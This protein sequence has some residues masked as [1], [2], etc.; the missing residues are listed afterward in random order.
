MPPCAAMFNLGPCV[1]WSH[2]QQS[3]VQQAPCLPATQ[4]ITFGL[5]APYLQQRRQRPAQAAAS[6][7]IAAL[8]EAVDSEGAAADASAQAVA[9]ADAVAA[10]F[11]DDPINLVI[12]VLFG[13]AVLALSIVSLGVAYLSFVSWTDGTTEKQDRQRRERAG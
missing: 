12:A 2:V 5:R 7:A 13:G 3:A 6:S 10:A 8:A 11:A 1:S 4:R 9:A